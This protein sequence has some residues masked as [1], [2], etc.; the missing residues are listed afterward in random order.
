MPTVF[1][2]I[3]RGE[4]PG[5]LVWR[6]PVCAA[7]LDAYPLTDGH[8]LVVPVT[9]VDRWTDAPDDLMAHLWQVVGAVGRAQQVAFPSRRIGLMVMGYEIPHLH[10]HSFPTNRFADFDL[11]HK[12]RRPDP[13][14]LDANASALRQALREAG[15]AAQ[16]DAAQA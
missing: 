15:Y 4:R 7:F 10:I 16:V 14:R 5:R 6:D 11:A 1:S 8:T 13:R 9:E 12:D 3:I 2:Q